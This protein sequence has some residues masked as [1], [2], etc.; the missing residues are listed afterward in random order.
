MFILDEMKED[1]G[2]IKNA[3]ELYLATLTQEYDDQP[4]REN[5]NRVLDAQKVLRRIEH[6]K[7]LL[8]PAGLQ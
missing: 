7:K 6:A 8:K 2:I 4:T 5:L 3:M 1:F